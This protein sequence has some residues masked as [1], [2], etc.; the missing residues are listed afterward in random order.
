MSI[1][2]SMVKELREKT[3]AGMMDCKKA[4][5]ETQGDF[6]KAVDWLRTK[7]LSSAAKKAGRIAASEDRRLLSAFRRATGGVLD[8][9]RGAKAG[10][11]GEPV[12]AAAGVELHRKAQTLFVD[13]KE[14]K[15]T[16]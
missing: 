12:A 2:A 8:D 1:S 5:E 6:E 15:N 11:T 16:N 13:R 9:T 10:R 4:L 7:G 14:N 3:S